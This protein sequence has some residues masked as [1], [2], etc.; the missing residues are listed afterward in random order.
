MNPG[1]YRHRVTLEQLVNSGKDPITGLPTAAWGVF[2]ANVP[3]EVLT[4]P[5]KE[6]VAADVE[7]ATTDARI[8]IP[9]MP[10]VVETQ[11]I[12]W[13][14]KRFDITSITLD[15]TARREIRMACTAGIRQ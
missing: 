9:W 7:R 15:A 3:A 8:N 2:K 13:E 12:V 10:G 4:G 14:G 1:K 6:T 5:G 11:R